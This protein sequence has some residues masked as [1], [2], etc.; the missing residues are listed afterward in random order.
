MSIP[1]PEFDKAQIEKTALKEAFQ[2]PQV[3]PEEGDVELLAMLAGSTAQTLK[4]SQFSDNTASRT[5]SDVVDPRA[6][7]SGF[8]KQR[9]NL[10]TPNTA[11]GVLQAPPRVQHGVVAPT[12]NIEQARRP[13]AGQLELDLYRKMDMTDVYNILDEIKTEIKGIKDVQK[14][15]LA[16]IE[17]VRKA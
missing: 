9:P 3:V 14:V 15:L 1:Q 7:L 11:S 10:G 12:P 2:P 13:E 4:N 6:V 16:F 8:I 17:D 5:A